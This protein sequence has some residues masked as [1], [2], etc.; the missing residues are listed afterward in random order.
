MSA[1]PSELAAL[2]ASWIANAPAWIAAVR[3]GAIASRRLATDA[4]IVDAVTGLA[5]RRILDLGCGEGWLGRALGARGIAV[6]G[7]DSSAPLVDA[8]RQ[9]AGGGGFH[10][11]TYAELVADPMRAGGVFDAVVANFALLDDRAAPLL[12]ALAGIIAPGGALVIQTLH[13]L[14]AGPPYRDGWRVEDFHGF[15]EAGAWR[16]MPW[17]FRTLGSW[18]TLLSESGYAL[19]S[20]TEPLHPETALPLSLLLTAAPISPSAAPRD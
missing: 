19:R 1:S 20:L 6:V 5:P 18:L 13:P 16:K 17:Y 7:V 15:G 9:Q 3:T 8:A 12:A 11:L 2:E 10:V 14:G 4:A